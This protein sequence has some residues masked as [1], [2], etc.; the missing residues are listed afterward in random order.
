VLN[1]KADG[2]APG[3]ATDGLNPN[4]RDQLF[5]T[6]VPAANTFIR[7][8]NTPLAVGTFGFIQMQP[9]VSNSLGRIAFSTTSLD[10][11]AGNTD[12]SDEVFYLRVPT[13]TAEVA[14]SA[15]AVLFFTGAS[16]RPVASASPT[17]PAVAG[18][19]PGMLGI[20][21]PAPS[22]APA[23][24]FAPSEKFACPN[25]VTGC[26]SEFSR[27]P[28][29]PT[30]LNGVSVSI[31]G[32]AAGLYFVSPGQINFVVPNGLAAS[33][34]GYPVVIYNGNGTII[35]TTLIVQAAQ[36]DIFTRGVPGNR[37]AV[38]NAV[39]ETAEPFTVTTNGQ[40]T[41]LR[42]M[43]TGAYNVTKSQVAVKIGATDVPADNVIKAPADFTLDQRL[44]GFQDLV[45]QLPAS[46]AGAGDVPVIVTVT[47]SGTAF[48]SRPADSGAPR[49]QIN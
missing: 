16:E 31:N 28:S 25:S 40:P 4:N 17:P 37:A 27:S 7:L 6:P 38:V 32:G 41:Q 24:S 39:T 34:T 45:V 49:I 20:A 12:G 29:L 48:T 43:L 22:P 5:A 36:P 1:F 47:I 9:Y 14:S 42:I 2:T 21:R 23:V 13:Q 33:T 3:T 18:L 15:N 11:G 35:R 8:T 10:V 30:E 44:A 19:A 26:A 46:L